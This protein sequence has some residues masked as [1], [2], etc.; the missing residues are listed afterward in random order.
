MTSTAS[1]YG[2]RRRHVAMQS[3]EKRKGSCKGTCRQ[4][5]AFQ[6]SIQSWVISDASP[7][8]QKVP[9]G[10]SDRARYSSIHSRCI[11]SQRARQ[12]SPFTRTRTEVMSFCFPSWSTAFSPAFHEDAK[13]ML[14][15][16]LNKVSRTRSNGREIADS[17]Y[18]G[19]QTSGHPG[20][21]R[22]GRVKHGKDRTRPEYHPSP[23]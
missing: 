22:S 17:R 5:D 19:E 14:E 21:D 4:G 8:F 3:F 9:Q 1:R 23:R 12:T 6:L 16:A 11:A 2:G 18:A 20:K 13:A 10:E 15:G 7:L